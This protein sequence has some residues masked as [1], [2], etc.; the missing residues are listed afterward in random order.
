MI[1]R[2]II[3]DD[4]KN[5]VRSSIM[6]NP[7]I[8][9]LDVSLHRKFCVGNVIMIKSKDGRYSLNLP[10]EFNKEH[11][12]IW[13]SDVGGVLLNELKQT[14]KF[15]FEHIGK[16]FRVLLKRIREGELESLTQRKLVHITIGDYD[17]VIIK[18]VKLPEYMYS[19]IVNEEKYIVD[20]IIEDEN[21]HFI[22]E[23]VHKNEDENDSFQLF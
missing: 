16:E 9:P 18:V 14:D 21:V 23:D 4:I 8:N 1:K 5:L 13:K 22:D 2:T 20:D 3:T 6:E 12:M 11:L 19:N 17:Y 10:E 7:N 15:L